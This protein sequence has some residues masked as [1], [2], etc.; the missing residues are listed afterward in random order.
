MLL[1]QVLPNQSNWAICWIKVGG[2]RRC[3]VWSIS[4]QHA[5]ISEL[6]PEAGI[7][8]W[9][10]LSEGLWE[11][12]L[13]WCRLE[14]LSNLLHMG[15]QAWDEQ[16]DGWGSLHGLFSS[17]TCH[18]HKVWSDNNGKAWD[19]WLIDAAWITSCGLQ[20][21][22]DDWIS[23]IDWMLDDDLVCQ[24]D[25]LFKAIRPTSVH[26]TLNCTLSPVLYLVSE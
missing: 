16:R 23:G 21:F 15:Y 18:L 20:T 6:V 25:H 22:I 11:G 17:L 26:C 2:C 4:K 14:V 5:S 8:S 3:T 7:Q 13:T 12:Q 9:W 10:L 19:T 24:V 1:S